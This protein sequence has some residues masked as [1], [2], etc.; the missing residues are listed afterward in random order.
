MQLPDIRLNYGVEA[1]LRL[2]FDSDRFRSF[3]AG[4]PALTDAAA[5]IRAALRQPT[6]FPPLSALCVPGDRVT[7]VLDPDLPFAGLFLAEAVRILVGAGV[8]AQDITIVEPARSPPRALADPRREL[9]D[10]LRSAVAW[11]VHDPT[12]ADATGYLA[13]SVGGERIYLAR[14][15]LDADL[16]IPFFAAGFDSVRGYQSPGG[17]LFPGL[18]TPD[19][20]AKASGE[21]HR[22]LRPEDDRPLRQL[23]EEICW[24][25]GIQ[26]AVAAGPSREADFAAAVWAGQLEA[27]QRQ[28]Q[29]FV[30]HAWKVAL[31][32]RAEAVVVSVSKSPEAAD[33]EHIGAAL[34]AAQQLVIREGRILVVSSL[35]AS[36]GPGLD[37][38]RS[39][40]SP[41]AALQRLRKESPPDLVASLQVASAADWARVS[42]LSRL[43]A[44][45]V[46][47][48][49][50]VP[51]ET[52]AEAQRLDRRGGG[53]RADRRRRTRLG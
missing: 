43:E 51:V 38:A 24:L 45:T 27:V 44:S 7:L 52:A 35:A 41:K 37:L 47:D 36:E 23:G 17:L 3:H 14:E 2:A 39:C 13:N 1:P 9:P 6:D 10:D 22:E 32:R 30:N 4:P 16:V 31:D 26:F 15:L 21:G 49:F 34:A 11:K 20:F 8:S 48:L 53:R 50:L 18:S 25:L 29:Q 33:W 5:A 28:S 40:R 19:A 42:L 12:A 46:E